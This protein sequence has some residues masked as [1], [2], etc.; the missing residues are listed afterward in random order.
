MRFSVFA[1][2]TVPDTATTR[3]L[4]DL[5]D[6]DDKSVAKVMFHRRKQQTGTSEILR[7]DQRA[8]ACLT[9]IHH[10]L[11][12]VK[13]ESLT[14]IDH[15]E[16]DML[17]AFYRTASQGTRL[18][19]WDG[20]QT[21]IPLIHFRSLKHRI[22]YPTYWEAC[23]SGARIHLDLRSWLS[24]TVDDRPGIH[25]TARKLGLP[26]MLGMNDEQVTDAWL[27]GDVDDV[28]AFSETLALN[29]YLLA[30]RL[31]STTGELPRH[32]SERVAKTLREGL[33]QRNQ[34]HIDKFLAAWSTR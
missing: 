31:F 1:L 14:Y 25:E 23:R 12:G 2:S 8:V 26:G 22:S 27:R 9:L 13:M 24:P 6:L 21:L 16:Q 3:Q 17:H 33:G 18:V 32:D 29:A 11:D 30:M 4:F 19:S 10:T 15:S 34:P 7:W 28:R 20:E 5:D